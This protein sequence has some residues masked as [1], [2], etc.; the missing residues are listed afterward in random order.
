LTDSDF[1]RYALPRDMASTMKVTD[2][3]DRKAKK[4]SRQTPGAVSGQQPRSEA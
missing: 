4:K 2:M 3:N 1:L